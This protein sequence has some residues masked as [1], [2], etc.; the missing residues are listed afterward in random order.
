MNTVDKIKRLSIKDAFPQEDKNLTPWLCNNIDVVGEAINLT[1]VS[2]QREKSTGNFS[3]DIIAETE[4]GD[5]VVIENQFGYSDHDHLGKII[6]YLTAFQAKAA[7]W[8]VEN[9]KQEH[10][11]AIA[12]L[13]ERDNG[14]DFYLLKMEAIQIGDSKLA[15]LFTVISGPSEEARQIGKIKKEQTANELQRASYWEM[16]KASCRS[17]GLRDF[18][19]LSATGRDPWIAVSSGVTGLSYVFWVNQL[20]CRIEL[21]ID[22]GKGSEEENLKILHDIEAHKN[23]IFSAF[24]SELKFDELEGYRVCS[25]RKDYDKYGYKADMKSWEKNIEVLVTE[26]ASLIK[27]TR[28]LVLKLK[29][30]ESS[31]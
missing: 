23:E 22:R 10:I 6:T 1:L 11:N 15:P 27:A 13:N 28:N 16:L 9:T 24:G 8:I 21:R 7:I 12:W 4:S 14:C 26:M 25:I 2:P 5:K 30:K 20:N 3:V 18:I 29:L 19:N 17:H 31:I